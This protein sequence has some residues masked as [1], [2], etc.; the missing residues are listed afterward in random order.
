MIAVT[1]L[2]IA[3]AL[4]V[5]VRF[6][7]LLVLNIR[8][9]RIHVSYEEEDTCVCALPDVACLEYT[10]VRVCVCVYSIDLFVNM[11]VGAFEVSI[12]M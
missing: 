10:R 1:K 2:C 11:S 4:Y 12:C 3:R 5:C 9:W 7:M 6:L 8:M